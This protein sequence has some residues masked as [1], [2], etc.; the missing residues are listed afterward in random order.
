M[1]EQSWLVTWGRRPF[2]R[3][4][5]LVLTFAAELV[6]IRLVHHPW[7]KQY[8]NR[9]TIL[10]LFFAALL[11]FGWRRLRAFPWDHPPIQKGFAALHICTAILVAA[12]TWFLLRTFNHG[13][14]VGWIAVQVWDVAAA[15]L[16]FSLAASLFSLRTLRLLPRQLGVA[17]IFAAVCAAPRIFNVDLSHLTWDAPNSAFGHWLQRVTFAGVH[18]ILV[19]FYSGVIADPAKLSIG[20]SRFQM[21]VAGACSGI[22]GLALMLALTGGWIIFMRRELRLTRALLLVPVALGIMWL[23]N[24]ARIAALIAIGD[25][26]HSAI[27]M[28]GF[29]SQA[30]WISFNFVGLCFVLAANNIA[31]FRKAEHA[32]IPAR[33]LVEV[34]LTAV[35]LVPFLAVLAT[36]LVCLAAS[37]G[38]EWLYPLRPVVALAVLWVYRKQYRKID[39]SFGWLG[40]VAGAFVFVLW[41]VLAR[42]DH[43][44]A[45]SSALA[46]GLASLSA[47]QRIA[48]IGARTF[49]AVITVPIIEELA[50][51]GYLARRIM[52]ADFETV[53]YQSLGWLAILASS[54][55]FGLM[56]G[57]LWIA[58]TLAG[59]VFALV[60]R[61]RGKFGEA[62]AAHATAN[63]L[64][65]IW[66]LALG[67]Y[68]LW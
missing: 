62:V 64:L 8:G 40:V 63:L 49:S 1:N 20:T 28:G 12:T 7:W 66:V 29:H 30:G 35:Y 21:I 17:W 18:S 45:A 25:A 56:H 34:N 3:L 31:W 43:G 55:G 16:P 42:G 11:F 47:A 54:V 9:Q 68:R 5:I 61:H 52:R 14:G 27:A 23:A 36:S 51:R 19:H 10:V 53:P 33:D 44:S 15:S 39:W 38:F 50:F 48:W 41:I 4:L 58:G 2:V 60:A 57:S 37:G 13:S 67:D 65:A 26:G 22:E 59:I 24:M 6:A 46:L 32:P